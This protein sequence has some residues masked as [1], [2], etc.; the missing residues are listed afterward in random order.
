MQIPRTWVKVS[1]VATLPDGGTAPVSVWG[2]GDN[3]ASANQRGAERLQRAIERAQRKDF[4]R[5]SYEYG[6]RPLREEILRTFESSKQGE[7]TAI[8]TRNGYGA[9][10]LNAAKL[11][12]LDIDFPMT[13][14]LDSLRRLFGGPSIEDKTKQ[15]LVKALRESGLATF[16]VYRTAFGLRAIAIDREFDPTGEEA[17]ALMRATHTDPS[18]ARLCVIQRSFRARLTPKPW[19]CQISPPPGQHPRE[20]S[21]VQQRF[22]EWLRG[23]E[24]AA[25]SYATCRYVETIGN[26]TASAMASPLIALHDQITRCE[27]SLPLA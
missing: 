21:G 6:H 10:V 3:V 9:L 19:R 13:N 20:D 18:F 16:R 1:A 12:F 27:E 2:W 5:D 25:A 4:D 24:A 26:G 11:L 17:Q 8:V 23:Y 15:A 22:A 7:P 14:P